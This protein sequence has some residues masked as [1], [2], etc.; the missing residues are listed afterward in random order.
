[1][2]NDAGEERQNSPANARKPLCIRQASCQMNNKGKNTYREKK[3]IAT[4][5]VNVAARLSFDPT[6]SS[7]RAKKEGRCC[8]NGNCENEERRTRFCSRN[9]TEAISYSNLKKS[10]RCFRS[11]NALYFQDSKIQR[12][13]DQRIDK[14][15]DQRIQ[16]FKDSEM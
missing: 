12:F 2:T 10:S 8:S 15:K 4:G 1:M 16:R 9:L 6:S 13:E 5:G 14:F 3:I 7:M 11:F